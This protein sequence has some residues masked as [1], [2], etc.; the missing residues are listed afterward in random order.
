MS[1]PSL[2]TKTVSE[3][4]F[5]EV[6]RPQFYKGDGQE[7]ERRVAGRRQRHPRPLGEMAVRIVKKGDVYAFPL[8]LF[9]DS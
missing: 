4:L 9:I 1:A 3:L 6:E 2:Q 5:L 7:V 8:A